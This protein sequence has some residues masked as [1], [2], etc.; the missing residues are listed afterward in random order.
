[1][2][3]KYEIKGEITEI[4]INY[5]GQTV[6]CKIDTKNL[7]QLEALGKIHATKNKTDNTLYAVARLLGQS[8]AHNVLLHRYLTNAP[9]QTVVDHRDRDGLNNLEDNLNITNHIGNARNKKIQVT[10]TSGYPGISWNK[11]K[12][13]WHARI[14]VNNKQIFLGYHAELEDAITAR[15]EA[16]EEYWGGSPATYTR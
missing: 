14:W 1:M 15:R 5:R 2:R 11:G 4:E 3:N 6:S 10:N 12:G 7:P 8:G 13:K 16:E 9:P